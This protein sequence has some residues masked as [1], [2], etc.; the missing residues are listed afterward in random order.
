M[1][2]IFNLIFVFPLLNLL[3]FFHNYIPDIGVVII[4][5]TLLVRLLL[6]PSFHKSLKHQRALA[7]LQPKMHEIREKYKDDKEAQ[8][9]ATM[10]LYKIHKVNP[11]SS[12]LPLLIQ[13]PILIG[14]YRVFMRSLKGGELAGLYSFV[15]APASINPM[16]LHYLDLSKP[17][18]IMGVIAGLLQYYLS[19]I[20]L[21]PNQP[22]SQDQMTKM[23]SYQTLYFLPL[24]TIVFGAQFPAGLT[25]YWIVTTLFGIGQQYYILRKE[26]KEALAKA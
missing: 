23:L 25:L 13:L 4:L 26:A 11:L 19:K 10:E 17:N 18:I 1:A 5:I 24:L 3:V 21:P 8:A 16:F 14:L 9:K 6:L 2:N 22:N 7:A 20:S 15:H 12:C